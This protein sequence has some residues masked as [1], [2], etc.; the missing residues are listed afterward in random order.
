MLTVLSIPDGF[1]WIIFSP[2][3]AHLFTNSSWFSPKTCQPWW[4][5]SIVTESDN[6]RMAAESATQ[7]AA[8]E[9]K[10][11]PNGSSELTTALAGLHLIRQSKR[12]SMW[13][14]EICFMNVK[15]SSKGMKVHTHGLRWIAKE[16][17]WHLQRDLYLPQECSAHRLEKQLV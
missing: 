1:P 15:W 13:Y 7:K 8:D 11:D 12:K 3:K 5:K 2:S 16:K 9:P 14:H 6:A 10:P 4:L 17:L